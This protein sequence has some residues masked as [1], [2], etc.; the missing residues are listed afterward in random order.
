MS[1][2]TM[3][4]KKYYDFLRSNNSFSKTGFNQQLKILFNILE[5]LRSNINKQLIIKNKPVI[6]QI[7]PTSHCNLQ[8]EMCIR[9]KIGVPIG[10]MSFKDFKRIL[11]KLDSLSK[12]HLSG[13]GE[14][15]LNKDL[16]NMI[17]YANKRGI[18]VF[19]TTNG[20]FLTKN[21]I[22]KICEVDIGE[23]GISIDS[24]N[25]KKYEKIRKGA[26]FENVKKNV[27]NL[28]L[29]LKKRKKKTIV[30]TSAVILKENIKEIPEFVE[31]ANSLGIKKVGFQT[32]QEKEDYID[33]YNSK[34]KTQTVSNF[35]RKLKEKIKEAK[36]IAK[37]HNMTVI[38]DEEK[39]P[40][41]IWP[42]RSIYITWNGN[43]TPCCKILD[44]RK[45]FF[46]NILKE[47]FWKIWNGKEYQLFRKLL[48]KRKAPLACKGC[49]MV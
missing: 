29:E 13:Q 28:V 20:T 26:K 12:I 23:I 22:N 30:S 44:Y 14:P 3:K 39:S 41:C 11:E 40:G 18:I 48:R 43:I 7:E 38:F 10:T 9:K 2:K 33:K 25:K 5:Y 27:K 42:W 46:G 4:I 16:F 31:L 32:I 36:R 49:N 17:K 24:T 8:C 37:K 19:F 35:N 47:N 34:I 1:Y 6:A 15:L 45:P 21:I